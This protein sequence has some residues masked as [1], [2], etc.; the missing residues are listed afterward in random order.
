MESQVLY[1]VCCVRGT[2][3][4]H[5]EQSAGS[6]VYESGDRTQTQKAIFI[7]LNSME[8]SKPHWKKRRFVTQK[9]SISQAVAAA[10]CGA[11]TLPHTCGTADGVGSPLLGHLWAPSG[12]PGPSENHSKRLGPRASSRLPSPFS[13]LSKLYNCSLLPCA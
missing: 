7:V 11:G 13:A 6:G 10:G 1:Q 2:A 4:S 12:P 3:D 8:K 9:Q 5:V